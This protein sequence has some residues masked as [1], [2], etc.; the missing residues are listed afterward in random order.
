MFFG[1]D[2]MEYKDRKIIPPTL[3]SSL[4]AGNL[5]TPIPS[6]GREGGIY[7]TGV[8]YDAMG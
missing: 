3:I 7:F 1:E 8:G 2:E 6:L 4:P 5:P